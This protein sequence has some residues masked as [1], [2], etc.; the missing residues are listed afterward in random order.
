MKWKDD[1]YMIGLRRKQGLGSRKAVSRK[2]SDWFWIGGEP[3]GVII[4]N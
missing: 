1:P 3:L 2:I 4:L